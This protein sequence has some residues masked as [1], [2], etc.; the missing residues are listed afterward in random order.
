MGKFTKNEINFI[1]EMTFN[2]YHIPRFLL[3]HYHDLGLNDQECIWLIAILNAVPKGKDTMTASDLCK[4]LCFQPQDA[5]AVIAAFVKKG[6]LKKVSGTQIENR[7]TIKKIYEEMLELWVF[8]QACPE[9]DCE[10]SAEKNANEK[11]LT[12]DDIKKIYRLFE[13][14]KGQPLSPTEIEKL[15]HW[16][17]DDNWSAEMIKEALQRAVLHGTC[18]FAYIDKILLRWQK[19]GIRHLSQLENEDAELKKTKK[20]KS[21]KKNA[22]KEKILTNDTDYNDIYKI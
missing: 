6:L 11:N 18:S 21:E 5:E 14:E 16:I 20:H 22:N 8:R 19:A 7:Y 3:R 17:I 1:N 4:A 9:S 12:P 13:S 2:Q 10:Q 15:N